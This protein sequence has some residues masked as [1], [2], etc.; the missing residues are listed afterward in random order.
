VLAEIDQTL[1]TVVVLLDVTDVSIDAARQ[2]AVQNAGL[3]TAGQ[4]QA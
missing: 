2:R 3:E 1:S 4:H